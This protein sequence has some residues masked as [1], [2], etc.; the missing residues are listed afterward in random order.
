MICTE[1]GILLADN[2]K[3]TAGKLTIIWTCEFEYLMRPNPIKLLKSRK[4]L[5][6]VCADKRSKPISDTILKFEWEG[7]L[8][9]HHQDSNKKEQR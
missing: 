9:T 7:D 6:N 4:N 8:I 2:C 1:L 5:P 3:W